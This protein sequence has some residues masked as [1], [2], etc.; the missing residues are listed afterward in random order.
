MMTVLPL[1]AAPKPARVVRHCR[2]SRRLRLEVP[3][4][5]GREVLARRLERELRA[6]GLG[7]EEVTADPRSGRL[8]LRYAPGAPLLGRLRGAARPGV[9]GRAVPRSRQRPG[10]PEAAPPWHALSV[11][12]VLEQLAS[13]RWGLEETEAARRLSFHGPNA[14]PTDEPRSRLALLASQL[15]NLP[16]ILLVGS[17]GLAA[18]VRDFFDAGAI[19]SAVGLDA[20]IGYRIERQS[21]TL[22]ASWH[23]LEAGN[24]RAI[25]DGQIRKVAAP[26]L[27]PGD[28]I[29]I[30]AGDLVPADARAIDAHRLSCD[31]AVLTGESEP[32]AKSARPVGEDAALA[33]RTC[34]VYAGTRV[35][36]GRARVVVTATGAAT[37]TARIKELLMREK[38]PETPFERR[39]DRLSSGLA[40]MGAAS[41]AAAGALG[42][43]RRRP[44]PQVVGN[45]VALAVAAIPEGLPVVS[46]AALVRSMQRLRERGMVVRHLVSAETLGGVT[47]VCADKTGTLTCN[48]MRLEV[49]DLGRGLIDADS[50]RADAEKLFEDPASLLLA[51]AVLNSDI[52]AQDG[53]GRLTLSGSATEKALV[54]AAAAAGLDRSALCGTYP[55]RLLRERGDGTQY[56]VSLH[57]GPGGAVAFVKGAPEQVV[58]L[59][60]R[61]LAGPLDDAARQRLCDRNDALADDG[62]RV[63]AVGWRRVDAAAGPELDRG[64]TLL[65]LLGLRDLLRAGAA[66]TVQRASLAGIRTLILTGDQQRTAQAVARAVGLEGEVVDGAEVAAWLRSDGREV[67]ERLRRVAAISRV[68][69]A[70]KAA[71]V[72]ALREAGEVVAMAGDGVND[73]PAIQAADVGI[74]IGRHASDVS[75]DAADLVMAS[76]DLR[77]ILAAVG[78][79]RVVQDNLR[80]AVRYLLATNLSESALALG[81]AV[82]GARDPFTPLRLLWLNLLSDTVPAL[83]LAT[84]P[85]VGDVL[86]R[87]PA[88]PDA[89]LVTRSATREALRDGLWI[90]G[91]GAASQLVAGP[92]AAFSGLTGAQLGYTMTCRSPQSPPDTRFLALLGGTAG[93]HLAAITLPPLRRA[94]RLPAALSPLELGAFGV[95]FLLPW[96]V[97]RSARDQVIVRHGRALEESS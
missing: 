88:P 56:V 87:P 12:Q 50:V 23:R 91:L 9:G 77:S 62:L 21:E 76:E 42:L 15:D 40:L 66:D 57:D 93:L 30:R 18:L 44:V 81:A 35:A 37:E 84:E 41:G 61:D 64:Y 90:A 68:A 16:S 59:C 1:S 89:P 47:V 71:I 5:R 29:V 53:G 79:G 58:Q 72:R 2:A 33:E 46:T 70:D 67:G 14:L 31:E 65:G 63:L 11:D 86:S 48:D 4:L 8:L 60:D 25:R 51:A 32:R 27:V 92:A 10:A 7:V 26:E 19:L 39:M 80:R 73:A 45:A 13:N 75:R 54:H 38:A 96:V 36:S 97:A 55:R 24:A 74:A 94:L 20:T 49:L 22:L 28:A 69:P 52:E 3:G 82:I 78:E 17:A 95:G 6:P 83:A 43:L 85:A 34:M